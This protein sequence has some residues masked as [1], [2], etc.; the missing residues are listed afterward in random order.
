MPLRRCAR[1]NP[2]RKPRFYR[3]RPRIPEF[4]CP[5]FT[6]AFRAQHAA[7]ARR[8]PGGRGAYRAPPVE[9][10]DYRFAGGRFELDDGGAAVGDIAGDRRAWR[11]CERQRLALADP[12]ATR[13]HLSGF[14]FRQRGGE[15][16]GEPDRRER[17]RGALEGRSGGQC[18]HQLRRTAVAALAP[19]AARLREIDHRHREARRNSR[20]RFEGEA[21]RQIGLAVMR[22]RAGIR[23]DFGGRRAAVERPEPGGPVTNHACVIAAGSATAWLRVRTVCDCPTTW[24]HTLT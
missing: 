22:H 9:E 19:K 15:R 4:H 3:A 16:H 12:G 11:Q 18:L 17:R 13:L 1:G 5:P 23:R 8:S 10:S 21:A 7:T 2:T 24:S 20:Q 6:G 14:S